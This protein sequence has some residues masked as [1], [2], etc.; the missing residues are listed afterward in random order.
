MKIV[1]SHTSESLDFIDALLP[2]LEKIMIPFFSP[3]VKSPKGADGFGSGFLAT[4]NGRRYLVTALHVVEDVAHY[5][6]CAIRINE[7]AILLEKVKFSIN[8]DNDLAFALIDDL[9][10][11]NNVNDAVFIDLDFSADPDTVKTD[12]HLLLGYPE[13]KNRIAPKWNKTDILL[14]S[15]TANPANPD[16]KIKTPILKR[17]LFKYDT[18]KLINSDLTIANQPPK[19]QGMSGGPSLEM[20]VARFA[21]DKLEVSILVSGV[22]VE[23]HKN[24][25]I[26][27]AASVDSLRT[28]MDLAV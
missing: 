10:N 24:E 25:K 8:K 4:Y 21:K 22:L 27:V 20:R 19:L 12:H 17:I 15:I 7:K 26:V 9:L 1:V 23:W 16:L 11:R 6:T 28:A 18:K 5:G 13:T 2:D 3:S 14:L